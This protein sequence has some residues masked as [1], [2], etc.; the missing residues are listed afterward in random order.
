MTETISPKSNS[1]TPRQDNGKESTEET[2]LMVDQF[3][4]I[5]IEGQEKTGIW[6]HHP[7]RDVSQSWEPRKGRARRPETLLQCENEGS[8]SPKS[9]ES[10]SHL[11][12][13]KS[14]DENGKK[15][16]RLG[17]IKRGMH[18]IG[19]MFHSNSKNECPEQDKDE[20]SI[21]TPRPNIR[22]V[23][24]KGTA[25]RVIYDKVCDDE[26]L[27]STTSSPEKGEAED[28]K[29]GRIKGIAK[30]IVKK[31][32]HALKSVLSRKGSFSVNESESE[33]EDR[34]IP[35]GPDST[36]DSLHTV[37]GSPIDPSLQSPANRDAID[38]KEVG[39]QSGSVPE[40]SL[41]KSAKVE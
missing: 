7:G 27:N 9:A 23:G 6:V 32:A 4:A 25:V 31:P 41:E 33:I 16:H 12:D 35:Q 8:D 2:H 36:D 17:T 34:E 19:M 38:V 30:S 40:K 15:V 22:S 28:T 21:P 26:T 14:K 5:D 37:K 3:E 18:K 13:N 29:R 24:E 11:N 1:K 39:F 10:G 20:F